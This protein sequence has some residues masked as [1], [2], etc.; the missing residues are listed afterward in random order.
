[1]ITWIYFPK[2]QEAPDIV[3]SVVRV[4]ETAAPRIHKRLPDVDSNTVLG[5]VRPGLRKL[6]F[7][8]ES[9]KKA[10]EKIRV[11]V[12]F[13]SLDMDVAIPGPTP[14]SPDGVARII[15]GEDIAATGRISALWDINDRTRL[16]IVYAGEN[17]VEFDSDLKLTLPPGPTRHGARGSRAA[18]HPTHRCRHPLA[19]LATH[20]PGQEDRARRAARSRRGFY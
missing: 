6:G 1:M 5:I 20:R 10:S 3:R 16:G 4:F 17:E 14:G 11:P 18:H 9:G 7:E 2:S 12:L 13:G 19:W 15:D 8:V